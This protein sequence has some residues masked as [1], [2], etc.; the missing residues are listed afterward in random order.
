MNAASNQP[1]HRAGM[2]AALQCY[3]SES[4]YVRLFTL[5]R[6][7]LAPLQK[8]ADEVPK[9]GRI[10]DLG[11]GHG[12]FTNLLAAGHPERQILGIDPSHTKIEVA[13]R[14][15]ARF[16]NVSYQVGRVEDVS[17]SDFD[18][19]TILDVL[20]LLPDAQKLE[21][22]KHSRL[23]IAEDGLL[24]VKTNDV[25]PRWKYTIVRL[26]EEL[27]VRVLDLTMGGEI[28]FRGAETYLSLLQEARFDAWVMNVDTWIPVP[29]R[30]YIGR[31]V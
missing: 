17:E 15:S 14:S 9:T 18:A 26:E 28:H 2:A 23:L 25:E 19:I 22:L 27:M 6:H 31:P 21:V 12:L 30:L 24:L 16:P 4:A 7:V 5:A 13:R 1:D 10:L 8:V 20:Y 11:C 3:S 29:H